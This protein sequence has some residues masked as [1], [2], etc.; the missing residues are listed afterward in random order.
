[1]ATFTEP[2]SRILGL[3]QFTVVLLENCVK[4]WLAFFKVDANDPEM[5]LR[6]TTRVARCIQ[7]YNIHDEELNRL[8]VLGTE[9]RR[10]ERLACRRGIGFSTWGFSF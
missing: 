9:I 6:K 8:R 7:E 3:K 5:A 10:L 2:R 4:L 1:M